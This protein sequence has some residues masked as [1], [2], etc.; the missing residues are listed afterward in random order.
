MKTKP[1]TA[2]VPKATPKPKEAPDNRIYLTKSGIRV[3]I[4]RGKQFPVH[5]GDAEWRQ[6]QQR[7]ANER[8]AVIRISD[9]H[10]LWGYTLADLTLESE[11]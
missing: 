1:K 7:E 11:D 8:I 6:Q 5:P 10:E 2:L 3:R 4:A 9:G